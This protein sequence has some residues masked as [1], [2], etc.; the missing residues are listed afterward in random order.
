MA[1][2]KKSPDKVRAVNL[3]I[4]LTVA[5]RDWL[6]SI[7]D[8]AGDEEMTKNLLKVYARESKRLKIAVPA[9]VAELLKPPPKPVPSPPLPVAP[10][11]KPGRKP[12][13]KP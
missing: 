3:N 2:P 11:P 9:T 6:H 5:E 7:R 1:R 13:K 10:A 8:K 4:R 12:R